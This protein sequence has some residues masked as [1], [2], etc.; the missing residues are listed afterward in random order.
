MSLEMLYL[1]VCRSNLIPFWVPLVT[2]HMHL[3]TPES[4][5][6]FLSV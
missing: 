1:I 5:L 6:F 4:Q 2:F 3:Y